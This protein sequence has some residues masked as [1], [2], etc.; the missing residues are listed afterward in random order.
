MTFSFF[1]NFYSKS[2]RVLIFLQQND[3]GFNPKSCLIDIKKAFDSI[4]RD[5]LFSL[6][7]DEGIDPHTIE[8]LKSIYRSEQSSLILNRRITKPF[9]I[10]KGVRQG[11][12]SS[13]TLFN[14]FPELLCRKMK[15]R[16]RGIQ[17]GTRRVDLLFYADDLALIAAS[18]ADL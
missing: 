17:I 2:T 9:H 1:E 15:T 6:L 4:N 18:R 14:L 8:I 12:C 13:P 3:S 5:Q 11:A 16:G 10:H 7:A